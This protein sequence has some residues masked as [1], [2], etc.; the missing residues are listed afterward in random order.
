MK[1]I[2]TLFFSIC[3]IGFLSAQVTV[4]DSTGNIVIY[5]NYDGGVLNIN[6]DQNI[7]NLKIGICS[8]EP[9]T[10]NI[11]GTY[12]GNVTAVVY[13]G[14]VA[15][16]NNHCSNSPTT[17]TINGVSSSITAV[18]FLPPSTL[19]NPNGYTSI[20][21]NYSCSST[22]NQGGCNTPDQLV[23]YFV[24]TMGGVF[25]SHLTQYG[26]WST[27]AY[28]VSDGGNCCDTPF[29][30]G[31]QHLN[32]FGTT[33]IFSDAIS[34]QIKIQGKL[35]AYANVEIEILNVYGQVV[36]TKKSAIVSELNESIS[37]IG[38][39]PGVYI[40]RLKSSGQTISKKL[41]LVN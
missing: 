23:S 19:A 22:T 24:T 6:V 29:P 34:N 38:F 28:N 7:P 21:C 1:K 25:R 11:G 12:V 4:C 5:S 37:T 36:W 31:I 26:C 41:S 3:A 18:N 40:V 2:I 17:S 30:L 15:T 16:N 39:T 14:Y 35:A 9:V 8:Y 13:A 20:V 10:V 27:T 33:E 32:T